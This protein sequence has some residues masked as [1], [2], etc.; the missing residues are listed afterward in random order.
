MLFRNKPDFE[1]IKV[2]EYKTKLP[3]AVPQPLLGWVNEYVAIEDNLKMHVV[4][5]AIIISV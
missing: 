4:F 3:E 2:I 1:Q 5:L